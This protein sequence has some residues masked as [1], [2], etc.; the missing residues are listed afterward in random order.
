MH[1]AE[2]FHPR[3][4]ALAIALAVGSHAQFVEAA[5]GRVQFAFG[6]VTVQQSGGGS[7]PLK[8]GAEVDSGDTVVTERGRVQI[9]FSDGSFVSLQPQSTFKID[10]YNFANR[11]DGSERSFFSLFRGGL[12]T[13]TGAI[14]RRNRDSYRVAT[15]VATIGIRGTEYLIQL[16]GSGA[17]V[18]VG[19]GAIAVINDA[20]EVVLVNGQ[21]GRIVDQSTPVKIVDEKPVL[22]PAPPKDSRDDPSTDDP[23]QDDDDFV[24]GIIGDN[25]EAEETAE[26]LLT[27]LGDDEEPPPPPP[28]PP[29]QKLESGPGFDVV[30]SYFSEDDE[31]PV[32]N[33]ASDADAVFT[34]GQLTGWS[35]DSGEGV[36]S[37]DIGELTLVEAGSDRY[38]GWGRWSAD[39]A[40]GDNFVVHDIADDFDEADESL[41]YVAGK[42]VALAEVASTGTANFSVLSHTSPTSGN[43]D[44]GTLTD[45]TF[46]IDFADQS[47]SGSVS[48]DMPFDEY[49]LAF[50]ELSAA[51]GRFAGSAFAISG[52]GGSGG[53]C[54]SG[55]VGG[56]VT[57]PNADR[58]GFVYHIGDSHLD[59]DIF[60]AVTF[61][62]DPNGPPP[63]SV[64]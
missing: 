26:N 11:D 48:V 56:I 53:C 12:R 34:E 23:Q 7:E 59:E 27:D 14:G 57:G 30:F 47:V 41:H 9:K 13:I 4:L 8:K 37:S 52:S 15:P 44:V 36:V 35:F 6:E 43:G 50:F 64:D 63:P 31:G 60:G 33:G 20:G 38:I 51:S 55:F 16:D 3:P 62:Q 29:P 45:A 5:A 24:P 40:D 1:E 32:L 19:D 22:P 58:A 46:G 42:P 49:D 61:L 10:E 28:P 39:E 21:T 2:T 25:G 54:Q 17:I 18:T